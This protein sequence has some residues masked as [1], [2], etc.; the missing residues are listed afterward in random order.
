M[1]QTMRHRVIAIVF[2]LLA[3]LL[4]AG[5]VDGMGLAARADVLRPS[6]EAFATVAQT[7]QAE[8][9]SRNWSGYAVANFQTGRDYTS[10]AATWVVPTVTV[11]TGV[12]ASYSDSWVGVGGYCLDLACTSV[13]QTLIQLGTEQDAF[14]DGSTDYFAW[15][16]LIPHPMH[17]VHELR[18]RPGDTIKASLEVIEVNKKNQ[19]WRLS[20]ANMTTGKTW[21]KDVKYDSSLT[22]AE[23]IQEAPISSVPAVLPLANYG[24][25]T[26]NPVTAN[27]VNPKLK[28]E[29]N[30]IVLV[31]PLG[32]TS[33][34]SKPDKDRDGFRVCWGSG[35]TLTP[36]SPP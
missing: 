1:I 13:D 28:F 15:Y 25:M 33:N 19:T 30:A 5:P 24:S 31:D 14:S 29:D 18:V 21:E 22:S 10:A 35:T 3:V 26:F 2:C 27:G 32:Q 7:V 20:I 8:R 4:S 9:N 16:D 11:P 12:S 6:T 17:R 36:C 34:P 23:W